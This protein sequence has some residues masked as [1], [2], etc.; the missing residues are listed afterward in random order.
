MKRVYLTVLMVIAHSSFAQSGAFGS[1]ETVMGR[2]LT[3][4]EVA[5]IESFQSSVDRL[6]NLRPVVTMEGLTYRGLV[7][8][9]AS[10]TFLIPRFQGLPCV[11][12]FGRR[13]LVESLQ[14]HLGLQFQIKVGV[15][16]I[17]YVGPVEFK[18]I[19]GRF[20]VA[21]LEMQFPYLFSGEAQVASNF[22]GQ[23]LFIGA[24][25]FGVRDSRF[26]LPLDASV[27]ALQI[28]E[29]DWWGP[30][31]DLISEKMRLR[32]FFGGERELPPAPVPVPAE[33]PPEAKSEPR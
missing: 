21:G 5:K 18:P 7:C 31:Q 30:I 27:G 4:V 13:F 16:L 25:D 20:V 3:A 8:A 33:R 14:A 24:L 29:R 15:A 17:L 32:E 12:F 28:S 10:A 2:K 23:Y 1:L 22:D 9:K 19:V 6:Q 11:D 26:N